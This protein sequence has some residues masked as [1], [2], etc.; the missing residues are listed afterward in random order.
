MIAAASPPAAQGCLG[1]GVYASTAAAAASIAA[2]GEA[3]SSGAE[4]LLAGEE[5]ALGRARRPPERQR[6]VAHH[7]GEGGAGGLARVVPRELP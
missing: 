4:I 2:E 6:A 3:G 5:P 1:E 7:Q